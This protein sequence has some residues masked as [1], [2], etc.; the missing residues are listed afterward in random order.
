[1]WRVICWIFDGGEERHAVLIEANSLKG[2]ELLE[3]LKRS[4]QRENA[5]RKPNWLINKPICL[6]FQKPLSIETK[7]AAG[8]SGSP[9]IILKIG[10]TVQK[11]LAVTFQA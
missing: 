7:G 1:L 8:L 2:A 10:K 9:F 3:S 6:K 4:N 11:N 5:I